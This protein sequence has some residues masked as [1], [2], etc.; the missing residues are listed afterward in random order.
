MFKKDSIKEPKSELNECISWI[1][2][3]EKS[4]P[5]ENDYIHLKNVSTEFLNEFDNVSEKLLQ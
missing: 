3:Y 4:L 5:L 1:S 2:K